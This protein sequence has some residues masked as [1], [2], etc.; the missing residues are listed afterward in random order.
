[1][2]AT[3]RQRV[4]MSAM[5]LGFACIAPRALAQAPPAQ[6]PD[7]FPPPGWPSPVDDRRPHTLAVADKLDLIPR[8]S[9]ELRWDLNGWSGGDLN[10]LWFKSEGDQNLSKAERNIDA[11]LLYGRFFGK[12]YDA[13]IGAGVQT[14]TFEGRNVNRVQ[15]VVGLEALVPFKSDVETLLFV[16]QKGD[17]SGRITAVR[18]YLMTQRLILQPRVETTIAAQQVREFTVGSGLN[19]IEIGFRLRYE[20]RREFGP[21][22]GVSFD[23]L[24][25]GTADLARAQGQDVNRSSVVFGVRMWR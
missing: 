11:Q 8:S 13:Q 14:A 7:R 5:V 22:V 6:P 25:F 4:V 20:I 1:M 18:D 19:N 23:R 21:Y 16:S 12:F 9:G 24:F 10:R 17:V 15:A 3:I 2:R